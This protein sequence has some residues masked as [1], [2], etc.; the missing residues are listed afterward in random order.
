[1]KYEFYIQGNCSNWI[2]SYL[3]DRTNKININNTHSDNFSLKHGV[4]QGSCVG[5]VFF[6]VYIN[7]MYDIIKEFQP[8]IDGFTDDH[9]LYLGFTPTDINLHNSNKH[10]EILII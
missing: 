5:P 10:I 8:D 6:L 4:L 1:M 3:T 7:C 2:N 9:Q